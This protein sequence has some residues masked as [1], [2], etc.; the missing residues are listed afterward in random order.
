MLEGVSF[1]GESWEDSED[2]G[3]S[4]S[5]EFDESNYQWDSS[6]NIKEEVSDLQNLDS[7]FF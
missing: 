1:P 4:K 5:P 7:M 2:Q 6:D 3:F